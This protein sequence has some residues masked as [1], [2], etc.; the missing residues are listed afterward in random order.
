MFNFSIF[1]TSARFIAQDKGCWLN[2]PNYNYSK[3][4]KEE[5]IYKRL[6]LYKYSSSTA[7]HRLC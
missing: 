4:K 6:G 5:V 3:L 7:L 2:G 1:V